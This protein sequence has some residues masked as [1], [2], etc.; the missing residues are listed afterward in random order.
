MGK[1]Q[2]A[3]I[4]D[5]IR[6]EERDEEN[7]RSRRKTLIRSS[8]DDDILFVQRL[9][10][11]TSLERA[12]L[13]TTLDE[14]EEEQ[15]STAQTVE[16]ATKNL[17]DNVATLAGNVRDSIGFGA[18]AQADKLSFAVG[19]QGRASQVPKRRRR[20][21]KKYEIEEEDPKFMRFGI[22][23]IM[24]RAN[25]DDGLMAHE[26]IDEIYNEGRNAVVIEIDQVDDSFLYQAAKQGASADDVELTNMLYE[27]DA[28]EKHALK[29]KEI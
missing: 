13:D 9:H 2:K 29:F 21:K 28:W 27:R 12:S 22:D 10:R 23:H 19:F 3:Q 7:K 15:C 5:M 17:A 1:N 8:G 25:D 16:S 11:A 6:Q 26:A 4:A 14:K 18:V 20:K 24:K